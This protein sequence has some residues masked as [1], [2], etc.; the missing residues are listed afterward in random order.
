MTHWPTGLE[1]DHHRIYG[2]IQ[3]R[4]LFSMPNDL[5]PF[6]LGIAVLILYLCWSAATEMGTRWPWKK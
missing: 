1:S 3:E 5:L 6:L 2:A 4:S